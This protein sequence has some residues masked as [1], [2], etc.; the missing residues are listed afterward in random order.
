DLFFRLNVVHLRLPPLREI[1][2]DIPVLAMSF[3]RKHSK[4]MGRE[5]ECFTPEAMKAFTTYNWPGNIRELENEVRRAIVLATH[6]QIGAEDLSEA[7][8]EE[9]LET[10]APE[11]AS[12]G[13]TTGSKQSLKLRVTALEIQM[14]RQAMSQTGGDKR[15]TAKMLGLS[16]QGLL[17]K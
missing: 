15:R 3:L 1:R 7:V 16:H 4:E 17:N 2:A 9:R 11:P 14:I 12:A 10:A 5:I 13:T 8:L 6:N